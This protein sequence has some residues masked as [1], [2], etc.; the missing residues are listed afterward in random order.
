MRLQRHRGPVSRAKVAGKN[1][2]HAPTTGLSFFPS[3]KRQYKISLRFGY[4]PLPPG[5]L[6]WNHCGCLKTLPVL[7]RCGNW[8]VLNA[9]ICAVGRPAVP[10]PAVPPAVTY[11]QLAIAHQVVGQPITAACCIESLPALPFP[12]QWVRLVNGTPACRRVRPRTVSREPDWAQY[13]SNP[14]GPKHDH[15]EPQRLADP[16]LAQQPRGLIGTS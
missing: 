7:L 9:M 3:T 16:T 5:G 12:V 14:A 1:K 15:S 4:C 2:V 10:G 13:S 8:P 6:R 11:G